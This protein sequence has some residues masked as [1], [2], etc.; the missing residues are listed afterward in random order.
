MI[1]SMRH[2]GPTSEIS[3]SLYLD[4]HCT[5]TTI[6]STDSSKSDQQSGIYCTPVTSKTSGISP[7]LSRLHPSNV[8]NC[9]SQSN[10]V[11]RHDFKSKYSSQLNSLNSSQEINKSGRYINHRKIRKKS[12]RETR[13][14][15]NGNM[16]QNFHSLKVTIRRTYKSNKMENGICAIVNTPDGSINHDISCKSLNHTGDNNSSTTQCETQLYNEKLDQDVYNPE[17]LSAFEKPCHFVDSSTS[18]VDSATLTEPDLLGPCEPGTKVVVEGVVWLEATGMLVLS[19]HWRGRNYMGTLLDSS[20]Q[21]FAPTCM[22]KGVASALNL[23]R[24]RKSWCDPH[25]GYQ[26]RGLHFHH[27]RHHRRGG[28]STTGV[29]MTT[30]SASAAAAAASQD[31][32]EGSV[33]SKDQS[34]V[35]DPYSAECID[36]PYVPIETSYS[37]KSGNIAL[38]DIPQRGAKGRRRRGAGRRSVRPIGVVSPSLEC[39]INSSLPETK[40]TLN[41]DTDNQANLLSDVSSSNSDCK[42]PLSCPFNGCEKRFADILSMRF[43]FTMG[44]HNS[45]TMEKKNMRESLV[46]PVVDQVRWIKSEDFDNNN[47]EISVCDISANSSPPPKLAR[48]HCTKDRSSDSNETSLVL[49]NGDDIDDNIDPPKLHRVVSISDSFSNANQLIDPG[50][51]NSSKFDNIHH[52]TDVLDEPPTASPAYSDISDDGT[53]SSTTNNFPVL[54]IGMAAIDVQN[55]RETIL[56]SSSVLSNLSNQP[57]I[58]QG[59][60]DVSRRLNLSPLILSSCSTVTGSSESTK[61]YFPANLFSPTLK[62]VNNIF[63]QTASPTV[64]SMDKQSAENGLKQN[65]NNNSP[66]NY[67]FQKESPSRSLI[68]NN[69]NHNSSCSSN[70]SVL[71]D[72]SSSQSSSSNSASLIPPSNHDN[73]RHLTFLSTSPGLVMTEQNSRPSSTGSFV[74]NP[75]TFCVSRNSPVPP[76]PGLSDQGLLSSHNNHHPFYQHHQPSALSKSYE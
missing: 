43:H 55:S 22:D 29:S 32:R 67:P 28:G 69:N 58:P 15:M 61:L 5:E 70:P 18:T 39:S 44:H 48:A 56:N 11:Q 1:E 59:Y 8:S 49:T 50:D 17:L 47:L 9:F 35:N 37:K 63:Y 38:H 57:S 30:R 41:D 26:A 27:L 12:K 34:V 10:R 40:Q 76:R 13:F 54:N 53:V 65:R 14:Q 68:T 64:K 7:V 60:I 33:D 31:S 46:E 19:L 3:S 51:S 42:L 62:G 73:S 75:L 6:L 25:R 71:H 23:L 16:D 36:Q 72:L 45:Q 20:K 66:T 4:K 52:T 21:T 2:R 24:G 74:T